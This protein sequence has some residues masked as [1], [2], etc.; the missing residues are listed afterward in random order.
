MF[1]ERVVG[2]THREALVEEQPPLGVGRELTVR[3]GEAS[4]WTM[5][6]QPLEHSVR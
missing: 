4:L 3:L 5:L 1:R 2:M 6:R